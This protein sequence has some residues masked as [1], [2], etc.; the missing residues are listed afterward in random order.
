MSGCHLSAHPITYLWVF[1]ASKCTSAES[2]APRVMST[3]SR[4]S[5]SCFSGHTAVE[6]Q[7]WLASI[8]SI[9]LAHCTAR[10]HLE[11]LLDVDGCLLST[12]YLF[13]Q[14][15]GGVDTAAYGTGLA[16]TVHELFDEVRG[17]R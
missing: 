2:P 9:K 1:I 10:F 13:A 15:Q 3:S 12:S 5:R 4:T 8:S 7:R 17:A 14:E 6:L 11:Q 16:K